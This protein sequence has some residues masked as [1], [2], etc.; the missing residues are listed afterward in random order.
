M[1][2]L[3]R[4][5]ISFSVLAMCLPALASAQ[6]PADVLKSYKAYSASMQ[7]QD[8]RN[9]IKHAKKAWEKAESQLG[10]H[11][12]T[13][14]LAYNYGYIEKNQG[15]KANA[16]DAFKRSVEL[17]S[18][19][20]SDAAALQLEREV[21]LVSSM[22]GNSRDTKLEKRINRAV[23]F[24]NSNGLGQ[25]VFVGEL[26][27]HDANVCTREL[28]RKMK[29]PRQQLGSLID[30]ASTESSIKDGNKRCAN[31]AKKAVDIFDANPAD[32][33]PSYVAAAN[34]YVGYGFEAN[35]NWLAA[36]LSYQKSRAAIED[37]YGR[38][39]P[40]VAKTIGRW[41]NV[42]NFL[43]R[44][45]NL[46]YAK[47]EGLCKC[48]PFTQDKPTISYKNWVSPDFPAKALKRSSGYAIIQMDV[49]DA[50][51]P[52]NVRVLSSWPEDIYD[53]SSL[54]AAEQL[55]F[56]PKTDDEPETY[57]KDVTVPYSY[58][59]SVGLEPI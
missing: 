21:E 26:Y 41:M 51:V 18:L 53:K 9:A 48:W 55:Q 7:S 57:R 5:A 10:D 47:S 54:K 24:A 52:E 30:K 3:K 27:V 17:A 43:K 20:K 16:I 46:E 32:T 58:Y 11:S 42:R 49:S 45:G 34:N 44:T 13:G 8:Y 2:F 22:D 31:I 59:L 1:T 56:P 4:L 14:D 36:A 28:H 6:T 38:D 25:T 40:L 15:D 12:M 37:V 39:N 33:R 29:I 19:A 35:K 50:G 23:D